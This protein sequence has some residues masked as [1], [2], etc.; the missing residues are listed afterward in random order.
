[1]TPDLT[2]IIVRLS[3]GNSTVNFEFRSMSE[4]AG[5][6]SLIADIA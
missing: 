5:F 1:M 4:A 3:V 6:L 2:H